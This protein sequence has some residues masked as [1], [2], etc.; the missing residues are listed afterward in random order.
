ME[1]HFADTQAPKQ[2]CVNI[3]MLLPDFSHPKRDFDP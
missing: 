2:Y 1:V 3:E